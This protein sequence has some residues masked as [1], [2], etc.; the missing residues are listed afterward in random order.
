MGLQSFILPTCW[1]LTVPHHPG[2]VNPRQALCSSAQTW[3]AHCLLLL[4][5]SAVILVFAQ[6]SN[7]NFLPR[8]FGLL[9]F[10]TGMAAISDATNNAQK[11]C[12][13]LACSSASRSLLKDCLGN[14]NM[15]PTKLYFFS[16][17]FQILQKI[18]QH[19]YVYGTWKWWITTRIALA[20]CSIPAN[21]TTSLFHLSW[22]PLFHPL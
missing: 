9:G 13:F 5:S 2:S 1:S 8:W 21:W 6:R 11:V 18:F 14:I 19:R 3:A 4:S 15:K 20:H 7:L 17:Y 10:H 12:P 22:G 16:I